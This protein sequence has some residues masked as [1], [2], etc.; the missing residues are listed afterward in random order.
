MLICGDSS[1]MQFPLPYMLPLTQC[2]MVETP[3]PQQQI[4]R[5]SALVTEINMA[6]LE[7]FGPVP[8]GF[9][10]C[11][12][13]SLSYSFSH[14]LNLSHSELWRSQGSPVPESM[15]GSISL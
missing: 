6:A 2:A 11:W 10:P 12:R 5:A 14:C 15:V 7:C 1:D 8:L 4:E 13:E 3:W 9:V